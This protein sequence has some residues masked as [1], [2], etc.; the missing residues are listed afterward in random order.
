M[1]SLFKREGV[2][3][4]KFTEKGKIRRISLETKFKQRARAKLVEIEEA[5]EA[6]RIRLKPRNIFGVN[7]FTRQNQ[8]GSVT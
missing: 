2:W 4:A 3:Y 8:L 7:S 1:G 6:G 5:L